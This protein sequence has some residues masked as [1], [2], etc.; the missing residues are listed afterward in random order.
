MKSSIAT[1]VRYFVGRATSQTERHRAIENKARQPHPI[2]VRGCQI[3]SLYGGSN[4]ISFDSAGLVFG[5]IIE[6]P[7]MSKEE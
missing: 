4:V 2:G 3:A 7:I 6:L 1:S 5:G